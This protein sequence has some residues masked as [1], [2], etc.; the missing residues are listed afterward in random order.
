VAATPLNL[1]LNQNNILVLKEPSHPNEEIVQTAL[2]EWFQ[3]RCPGAP[4]PRFNSTEKTLAARCAA[5]IDGDAEAKLQA[6][7]DSIAGALHISNRPPTARFIW[8]EVPH[9]FAHVERGA[10]L[11][12][13][14]ETSEPPRSPS[15][16]TEAQRDATAPPATRAYVGVERM[17]GDLERLFGPNWK[18]KT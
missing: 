12:R 13:S 5:A 18:A 4:T 16:P 14:K 8:G 10:A 17:A 6:L 9:F 7:R 3:H 1:K 2:T 15:P 11:R